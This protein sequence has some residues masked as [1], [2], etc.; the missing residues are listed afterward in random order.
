MGSEKQIPKVA[1]RRLESSL[2]RRARLHASAARQREAARSYRTLA[3]TATS[4]GDRILYQE[5]ARRAL[6]LADRLD[7]CAGNNERPASG[8]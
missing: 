3:D 6:E 5:C 8:A 2:V 7:R 4:A 1:G